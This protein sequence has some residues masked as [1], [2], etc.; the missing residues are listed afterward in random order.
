MATKDDELRAKRAAVVQRLGAEVVECAKCERPALV[1]P[2]SV[3]V[4]GAYKVEVCSQGCA[5]RVRKDL[6]RTG[7]RPRTQIVVR[8]PEIT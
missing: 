7:V 4:M 3:T 5:E 6:R 2:W 1:L 8:G